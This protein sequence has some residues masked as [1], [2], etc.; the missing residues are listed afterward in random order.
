VNT[1]Q[2]FDLNDLWI[3]LRGDFVLD[4]G[5][6]ARAIDAEFVRH[7]FDTGD[8]PRGSTVGVQGGIFE[9]WFTPRRGD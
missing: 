7:E 4:T 1:L 6:P 8:R 5:D 2:E 9:S 3:R